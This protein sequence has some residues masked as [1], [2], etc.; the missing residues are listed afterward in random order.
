M[1][2]FALAA[3]QAQ[4]RLKEVGIRKAL[5]ASVS[6]IIILLTTDFVKMVGIALFIAAPI[7]W[8]VMYNWL[9]NFAYRINVEW[10][11]F[12]VAG[13]ITVGVTLLTVGGQAF[14]AAQTNPVDSLRDE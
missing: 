11:I 13:M 5:G 3:F 4:Q 12:I 1:G 7:G 10:W 14:R 6:K 9:D 2:L 8:W